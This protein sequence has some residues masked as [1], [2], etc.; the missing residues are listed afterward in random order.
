M[1]G[2]GVVFHKEK[3]VTPL[4]IVTPMNIITV[5]TTFFL[6]FNKK[7]HT[8]I[9]SCQILGFHFKVYRSYKFLALFDVVCYWCFCCVFALEVFNPLLWAVLF[10]E[11]VWN[12]FWFFGFML[13]T[14]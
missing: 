1:V 2:E 4:I 7:P 9:P 3:D 14:A 10:V 5:K 12:G 13:I 11:E 8:I 6:D